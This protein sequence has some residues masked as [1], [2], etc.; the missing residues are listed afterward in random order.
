MITRERL[1]QGLEL[2]IL[3]APLLAVYLPLKS[4]SVA[5]IP[6]L[7]IVYRQR[8]RLRVERELLLIAGLYLAF[9][10]AFTFLSEGPARSGKGVYDVVRGMLLFPITLLLAQKLRAPG[11]YALFGALLLSAT[12]GNLLVPREAFYGF[13]RIPMT[14]FGYHPNPN[15]VAVMVIAF[16]AFAVLCF[17][18]AQRRAPLTLWL[19]GLTVAAGGWL[20][21]AA[22]SRGAWLGAAA[23]IG[24]MMLSTR[25][26]SLRLRLAA[27]G[28]AV[29]GAAG[30]LVLANMK[31]FGIGERDV[32]WSELSR[33]T[34]EQGRWLGFG[35]NYVKDLMAAHGLPQQTAHNLFLELFVSSGLV[36][37]AFMGWLLYRLIRHL[38]GGDYQPGPEIAAGL[39]GLGAFLAM[40]QFDLKLFSFRFSATVAIFLA[41]IYSRR[42]IVSGKR[43]D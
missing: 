18:P 29:A 4:S 16:L 34:W 26:V 21:A 17:H 32:I 42:V 3:A 11:M 24:L 22:N 23:G 30:L 8:H 40:G 19:G 41:L 31:G 43:R 9:L 37:L 5:M 14:F 28:V 15:N 27:A 39:A 33:I 7:Y 36:G 13:D 6:A 35:V 25:A 38:L 12:A 2:L 1:I 10:L 20:L